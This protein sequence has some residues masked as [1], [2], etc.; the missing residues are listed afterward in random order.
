M[1]TVKLKVNL[2]FDDGYFSLERDAEFAFAPRI[3]D[4][5]CLAQTDGDNEFEAVVRFTMDHF[6][7]G[8]PPFLL[9]D[10][11]FFDDEGHPPRERI[12]REYWERWVYAMTESGFKV[13]KHWEREKN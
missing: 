1:I 13:T 5:I 9:I 10:L 12:R 2:Y 8:R 3:G 4:C 11:G 6:I 7:D